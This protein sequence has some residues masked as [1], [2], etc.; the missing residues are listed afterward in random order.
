M[1][2][3]QLMKVWLRGLVH[4]CGSDRR[5]VVFAKQVIEFSIWHSGLIH[6]LKQLHWVL[7]ESQ[8]SVSI[9]WTPVSASKKRRMTI[10]LGSMQ[11]VFLS[12]IFSAD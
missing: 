7:T 4:L 6:E 3:I 9:S 1:L 5:V 11:D 2:L 8:K 10:S 12:E